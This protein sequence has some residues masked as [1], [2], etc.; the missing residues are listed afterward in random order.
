MAKKRQTKADLV[1]SN[2]AAYSAAGS[3]A[4]LAAVL[5][6]KIGPGTIIV[7]EQQM[8]NV[9]FISTGIMSLDSITGG[10]IPRGRLIEIYG[11]EGSGKTTTTLEIIASCQ[12]T[13]FEKYDRHGVCAFIDA[14]HSLDPT[15]ARNVGVDMK[16]IL[17][18]Q[19]SDGEEVF[20][21]IEGIVKSGLVDLIIVDS[22]ASMIPR[23]ELAGELSDNQIGAAGRLM[24]KGLRRIKGEVNKSKTAVVFINQIRQKVGVMFG[25]PETTPGGL[26]MKFYASVRI[27]L[28][29]GETLKIKDGETPYGAVCKA[30]IVKN[31]VA[32]PY[33]NCEYNIHFGKSQTP[34]GDIIFGV[35]KVGC[36]FD[37]GV[38]HGVI[39]RSGSTFYFDGES[40]G[41]G[42]A[43][44]MATIVGDK[45]LAEKIRLAIMAATTP[46]GS[47]L[48]E[49]DDDEFDEAIDDVEDDDLIAASQD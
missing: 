49:T 41:S 14:E 20:D 33:R 13:F 21:V 18:N 29:R 3:L 45:D 40:I 5:N 12:R 35:D 28:R 8:P 39:D 47:N 6:K 32:P 9:D 46:A 24:S 22:I 48:A 10:G 2:A 19:P 44:S 31:K 17:L 7:G 30:K 38:M 11:N 37:V 26:A 34:D 25:N 23:E 43:K 15:W 16:S 27:D 4:E 1:A 42:R 36:L